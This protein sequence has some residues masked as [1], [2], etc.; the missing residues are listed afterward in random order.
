MMLIDRETALIP[1]FPGIAEKKTSP[2]HIV[3]LFQAEQDH[4][5]LRIFKALF[6]QACLKRSA[7]QSQLVKHQQIAL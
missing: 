5:Q 6:N 3:F 7:S 1:L 4:V 2:H